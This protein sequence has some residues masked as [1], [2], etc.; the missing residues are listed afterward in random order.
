MFGNDR[1]RTDHLLRSSGLGGTRGTPTGKG[2]GIFGERMCKK[3]LH[4]GN[5]E[6]S[7]KRY[8]GM[9]HRRKRG[10]IRGYF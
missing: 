9:H 5:T 10:M 4:T 8:A 3:G 7:C 2:K 6:E 1:E